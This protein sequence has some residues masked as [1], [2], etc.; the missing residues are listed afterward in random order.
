M[1]FEWDEAK[2]RSNYT[3][4]GIDFNDATEVFTCVR[5]TSID[6]R[7]DYGEI[8]KTTVGLIGNAV[9]VV[10]YTVR[11]DTTRIISA[12][13]ANVK[14]RSKYDEFIESTANEE[15]RRDQG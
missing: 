14:E 2:N 8:R 15:T 12:R 3:K 9:C 10:V 4:H 6:S 11:N 7:K 5:A 1:T 13:K